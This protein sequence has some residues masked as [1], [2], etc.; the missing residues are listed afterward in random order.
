MWYRSTGLAGGKEKYRLAE[1]RCPSE[2]EYT[3]SNAASHGLKHQIQDHPE[4]RTDDPL[5]QISNYHIPSGGGLDGFQSEKTR[6]AYQKNDAPVNRNT[7]C[8]W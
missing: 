6:T 4:D 5:K 1:A 2:V 8:M 7:R 3:K